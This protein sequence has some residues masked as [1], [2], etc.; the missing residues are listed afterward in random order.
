MDKR[1]MTYESLVFDKIKAKKKKRK[2]KSL[3]THRSFKEKKNLNN[4][5]LTILRQHT[6]QN[7]SALSEL[8][9]CEECS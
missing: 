4:P 8:L 3:R 1:S 7:M 2:E 6:A 9:F 5:L